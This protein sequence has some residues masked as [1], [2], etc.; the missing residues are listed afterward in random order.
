MYLGGLEVI[1]LIS[2]HNEIDI[3]NS[4]RKLKSQKMLSYYIPKII[5]E[6]F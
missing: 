5:H 4:I 1:V 6:V 3:F 2:E